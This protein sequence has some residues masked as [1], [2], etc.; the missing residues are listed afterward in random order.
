MQLLNYQEQFSAVSTLVLTLSRG[1][2]GVDED[3]SFS[4]IVLHAKLLP[5]LRLYKTR[6]PFLPLL[7]IESRQGARFY[8]IPPRTPDH[9][10]EVVREIVGGLILSQGELMLTNQYR[11]V[12]LRQP[13]ARRL[14]NLK[15]SSAEVLTSLGY[16]CWTW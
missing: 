16:A 2:G 1:G 3:F 9:P 11:P 7:G 8:S 6:L 13:P 14:Q 4:P 5:Q 15:R 12:L 10:V